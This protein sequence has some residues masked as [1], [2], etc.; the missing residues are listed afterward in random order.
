M[1]LVPLVLAAPWLLALLWVA[2]TGPTV[3][4][5]PEPPSMAESA[6]Q[7]LAVR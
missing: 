1:I 5:G 7:R 4:S 3:K 2:L 6:R